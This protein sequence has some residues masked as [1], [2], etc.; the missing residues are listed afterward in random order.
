MN[1]HAFR[2][3]G[4]KGRIY[5]RGNS[6][7]TASFRIDGHKI[8]RSTSEEAKDPAIAAARKM[9][10]DELRKELLDIK[11]GPAVTLDDLPSSHNFRRAS[12]QENPV[13]HLDLLHRGYML[14]SADEGHTKP[15]EVIGVVAPE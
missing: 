10:T 7:W 13:P 2:E 4:I 8:Q 6:T 12:L 5:R 9:V 11:G 15:D 3:T 14:F 1:T